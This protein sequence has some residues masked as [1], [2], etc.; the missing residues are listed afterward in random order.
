MQRARRLAS[1]V[2]VAALAV[3][4]LTA[5]R[6]EPD[7]AAYI[8]T[9]GQ[10]TEAQVERVYDQARDELTAARAQVQRQ[11]QQSGASTEPAPP[12]QMPFKQQEALNVLLTVDLLE[13]AA[14]RFGV[15]A[16]AEPTIEQVVQGSNYSANWEYTRLYARTFQLRAALLPKVPPAQLSDAELRPVYERLTAGGGDTTP[17]DQFKTQLSDANKQ[18]LQQSL[19]LRDALLKVVADEHVKLNPR[20]GDQQV[21]LLSAN[22]GNQPLPL[23]EVSLAGPEADQAPFVTD[24]S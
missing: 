23:V 22:A 11:N 6:A 14:A 2:I 10:I 12:V 20:Y 16:A 5:C 17:Y 3:G 19:G 24:V 4:G 1:T 21:V 7:V 8:G 13:R 18:A 15:Q 9:D